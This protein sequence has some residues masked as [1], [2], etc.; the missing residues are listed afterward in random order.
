MKQIIKNFNNLVKKTIFKVQNK[1]NNNFIIS[2]FNKYL[3][4]IIA[5]LFIYLFYLLVPLLYEKTWIQTNIESKLLSEFNINL[6]TSSDISYRILPAPHFLIKDSIIMVDDGKK[7]KSIAEIKYFKVFLNQKNLFNKKKMNIKE[8]VIN[9][10]NFSF[11]RSDY[12]LLD[13]L[14]GK[15]FSSKKIKIKDSNIFFKDNLGEIISIIKIKKTV[16]FFDNK[17]LLNF[18]NLEGEVFNI[19]FVFNFFNRNDTAEYKEINLNSK[20]LKL[21]ILNKSIKKKKKI[22]F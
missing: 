5:S 7:N 12:S 15:K 11:L 9:H 3:I 10:A 13:K 22:T 19:P 14:K 17:K 16:T 21:N 18:L 1:T 8:L 20:L 6:S 2:S 4:A